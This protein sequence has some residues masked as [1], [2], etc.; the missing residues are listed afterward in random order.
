M[1]YTSVKNSFP[2]YKEYM[3][4]LILICKFA[5]ML[6]AFTRARA[7]V[8]LWCICLEVSVLRLEWYE[9]L[10]EK[11][12]PLIIIANILLSKAHRTLSL[13]SKSC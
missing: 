10:S 9:T 2:W 8:N 11:P 13:P 7:I 4:C 5:D 1:L 12:A 3:I 6:P